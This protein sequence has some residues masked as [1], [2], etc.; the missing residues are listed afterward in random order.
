LGFTVRGVPI[1]YDAGRRQLSCRGCAAPL[2]PAA[3]LH[4]GG[5]RLEILVDRTSIEIY[6]NGGRVYMPVGVVPAD[7][8]RSLEVFAHGGAAK[9]ESLEVWQ[10]R[11]AWR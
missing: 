10:L 1:V 4:D 9:A 6:G 5:I 8:N 2:A 11:S 3:G 7:A